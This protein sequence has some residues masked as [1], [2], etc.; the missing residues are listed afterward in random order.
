M[1]GLSDRPLTLM[2]LTSEAIA[3]QSKQKLLSLFIFVLLN[4]EEILGIV[5]L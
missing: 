4:M 2:I 1:L 5:P 3:K